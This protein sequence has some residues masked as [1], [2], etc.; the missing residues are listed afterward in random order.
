MLFFFVLVLFD[1]NFVSFG[2]YFCNFFNGVKVRILNFFLGG[3][4]F[5]GFM[6]LGRDGCFLFS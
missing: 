1:G 6:V 2:I 4:L 3:K 5:E